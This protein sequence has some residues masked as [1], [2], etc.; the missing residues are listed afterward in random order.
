MDHGANALD[1]ELLGPPRRISTQE[2]WCPPIFS[3]LRIRRILPGWDLKRLAV[4]DRDEVAAVLRGS[5]PRYWLF[6]YPGPT[7]AAIAGHAVAGGCQLALACDVRIMATGRPRL[8]LA[9]LNLGVPVPAGSLGCSGAHRTGGGRGSRAAGEGY[10][11]RRARALSLVQRVVSPP[12][13]RTTERE[14]AK[15]ARSRGGVCRHQ[16]GT[17]RDIWSKM[18][19]IRPRTSDLPRLLVRTRD[20][21][22]SP[23]SRTGSVKS[24]TRAPRTC[25]YTVDSPLPSR[26][27]VVRGFRSASKIR[28]P[29]GSDP[30]S[31]RAGC[32][33]GECLRVCPRCSAATP[34]G[35]RVRRAV[36]VHD[37]WGRLLAPAIP[38]VRAAEADGPDGCYRLRR[39]VH[40]EAVGRTP[41]LASAELAE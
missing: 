2:R 11:A 41:L 32:R 20:T 5:T 17:V 4:A 21:G 30:R 39:H 14:L 29:P 33:P 16:S 37:E 10:D 9:E 22:G 25:R 36:A 8:G 35:D 12:S 24:E 18:E 38:V 7:A 15:L 34:T 31:S 23:R 3:H 26:R 40:R 6:S 28:R 27:S 13:R 1:L 19:Q